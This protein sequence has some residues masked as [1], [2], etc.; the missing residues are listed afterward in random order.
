MQVSA[1]MLHVMA[2]SKFPPHCSSV[3]HPHPGNARLLPAASA[4]TI[5][6]PQFQ[7]NWSSCNKL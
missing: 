4:D 6:W 1:Q 3:S 2:K 7:A 5:W